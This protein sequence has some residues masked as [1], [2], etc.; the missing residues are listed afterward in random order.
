M[1]RT[2]F[3]L[4]AIGAAA[5]LTVT[6]G[7]ALAG[8][9]GGPLGGPDGARHGDRGARLEARFAAMDA[10]GDGKVTATE[11]HAFHAARFAAIDSDG[12]G[13]LSVEELEA[14]GRADWL[15]RLRR[16]VLWLDADGDGMLSISEYPARHGGMLAR[17][18]R[19]G[20]GALTLEEMRDGSKR[21]QR[22][23]GHHGKGPRGDRMG[24]EQRGSGN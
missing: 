19:D 6:A 23:M 5:A 11:T 22:G 20:D 10:D 2:K 3:T 1:T 21:F 16:M 24:G 12:D 7:I 18:D 14:A 15:E 4:A 17:M 13:R 8:P 9:H